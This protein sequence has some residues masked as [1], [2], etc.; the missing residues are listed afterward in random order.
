MPSRRHR[1]RHFYGQQPG[2]PAVV[3]ADAD[4]GDDPAAPPPPA[5]G[6]AAA[7]LTQA[8]QASQGDHPAVTAALVNGA[9]AAQGAPPPAPPPVGPG[10]AAALK[11]AANASKQLGDHPI[12]AATLAQAATTA[13]ASGSQ[14]A[15]VLTQAAAAS[16]NDHPAVTAALSNGAAKAMGA[17]PVATP[18]AG[19][20]AASA[21]AS[22]ANVA[23]S[24]NAHPA[25]TATLADAAAK[26]SQP[27]VAAVLAAAANDASIHPAAAQ[28]LANAA[29]ANAPPPPGH[30]ATYPNLPGAPQP[31]PIPKVAPPAPPVGF[32]EGAPPSPPA[33]PPPP[34]P[35]LA[36]LPA[37]HVAA[38]EATTLATLKPKDTT[39]IE[40]GDTLEAGHY[41]PSHRRGRHGGPRHKM[42]MQHD[43]NLVLYDGMTPIW[44]SHT[45]G[46]GAVRARMRTDGCFVLEDGHGHV[47]WTSGARAPGSFVVLQDDGNFVHY[48]GNRAVWASHQD[49]RARKY[50][51]RRTGNVFLGG[52]RHHG[53]QGRAQFGADQPA[54]TD[55]RHFHKLAHHMRNVIDEK[56]RRG[57]DAALETSTGLYTPEEIR[58]M[59]SRM[60]EDDRAGYAAGTA[61]KIGLAHPAFGHHMKTHMAGEFGAAFGHEEGVD[62]M[63]FEWRPWRWFGWGGG[64]DHIDDGGLPGGGYPQLGPGPT[65]G[66][67]AGPMP[68]PIAGPTAAAPPPPADNS[69]SAPPPAPDPESAESALTDTLGD[70]NSVPVAVPQGIPVPTPRFRTW[71]ER[72]RWLLDQ[73][74]RYPNLP[75]GVN[76][77]PDVTENVTINAPFWLPGGI[78]IPAPPFRNWDER[79]AW[80]RARFIERGFANPP[81]PPPPGRPWVYVSATLPNGQPRPWV[82]RPQAAHGLFSNMLGRVEHAVSGALP[83]VHVAGPGAGPRMATAPNGQPLMVHVE[84][85]GTGPQRATGPDG[86]PLMV[87][88][89]EPSAPPVRA[90]QLERPA[91]SSPI[92]TPIVSAPDSPHSRPTSPGVPR[93]EPIAAPAPEPHPFAPESAHAAPH[94]MEPPHDNAPVLSAPTLIHGDFGDISMGDISSF[95][96]SASP[97]ALQAAQAAGGQQAAQITQGV[98][99]G[100]GLLANALSSSFDGE[101]GLDPAAYDSLVDSDFNQQ[102]RAFPHETGFGFDRARRRD[103]LT[104]GESLAP[105]QDRRSPDGSKLTLQTDGNLVLYSPQGQSVWASNTVGSGATAATM[106]AADGNF[107]VYAGSNPVWSSGS[108]GNP[109]AVLAVT[110]GT[111]LVITN[112]Q[113]QSV[114][115][116]GNAAAGA[117]VFQPGPGFMPPQGVFQ[118]PPWQQQAQQQYL[119]PG[120]LPPPPPLGPTGMQPWQQRFH[121]DGFGWEW[122]W[123]RNRQRQAMLAQQ[124]GAYPG[125]Q[126]PYGQQQLDP[127]RRRRDRFAPGADPVSSATDAAALQAAGAAAAIG[128]TQLGHDSRQAA[129]KVIMSHHHLRLGALSTGL[130]S[131]WHKLV[132]AIDW[133]AHPGMHKASVASDG[134]GGLVTTL[135]AVTVTGKAG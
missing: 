28:A 85:H 52:S 110:N 100:V 122:P 89:S 60:P 63:G 30:T 115:T 128:T 14:V 76:A 37:A 2:Y 69:T 131:L 98:M 11:Q 91:V 45:G 77:P 44:A 47:K 29:V 73:R 54:V 134:K 49:A 22:A 97:A 56:H 99:Q 7:V 16:Q 80:E 4:Y 62:D 13:T 108:T 67:M 114:W 102:Y 78:Q 17:P 93:G 123:R 1:D 112:P 12:V 20:A 81:P 105:G 126:V 130:G 72:Q 26:A 23:A 38:V 68:I 111:G 25:V 24:G 19:P 61:L 125:M 35:A 42:V 83:F 41:I 59:L 34:P 87:H 36:A 133:I 55:P 21:L 32:A 84:G 65:P 107:V 15:Q 132:G 127:R 6:T 39:A 75:W 18:P 10:D 57:L 96:S 74:R 109:G 129:M 27:A 31:P 50:D 95:M 118:P 92:G 135:P 106:Q 48:H 88:V 79:R 53:Y 124:Q 5:A 119:P 101:M 33:A 117:P 58:F 104:P 64:H 9:A 121:G 113:D 120:V 46:T 8:A 43:G 103:R 90:S 94:E 40:P 3:V 82:N 66:P 116:A 70:P 71:A 86:Q 51:L